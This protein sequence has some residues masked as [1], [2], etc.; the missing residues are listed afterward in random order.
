MSKTNLKQEVEQLLAEVDRTHQYSMSRIY[1]L[2]NRVFNKE[3]TPQSCANCLIRKVQELRR[4]LTEQENPE[5]EERT[6]QKRKGKRV[7]DKL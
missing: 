2:T 1:Q 5:A 3:E 6:P 7:E 4:W